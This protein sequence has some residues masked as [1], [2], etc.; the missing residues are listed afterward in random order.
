MHIVWVS[1][2]AGRLESRLNYS[3]STLLQ[4]FPLSSHFRQAKAGS[5]SSI[6]TK[7]HHRSVSVTPKK[8]LPSCTTPT[9]CPMVCAKPIA[10]TTSR[11]T[12]L[13]QP[14]LRIRRERLEYLFKL[15]EQMIE[16]EKQKGTL[17]EGERKVKRKNKSERQRRSLCITPRFYSGDERKKK[18]ILQPQRG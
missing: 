2:F 9:K 13:P 1:T 18:T 15:Y 12:L 14:P 10:S 3:F 6:L 7:L 16:E 8:P 17:F 5:S 11:R 4:Y